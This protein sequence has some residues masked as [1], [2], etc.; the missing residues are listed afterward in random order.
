MN[1]VQCT[2]ISVRRPDITHRDPSA[3]HKYGR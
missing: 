2:N 1:M 3:R